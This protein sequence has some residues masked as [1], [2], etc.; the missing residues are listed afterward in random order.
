[1]VLRNIKLVRMSMIATD[2]AAIEGSTP[3]GSGPLFF[4]PVVIR[5]TAAGI[6]ITNKQYTGTVRM[7]ISIALA[8]L[9]VWR[10]RTPRVDRQEL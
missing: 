10:I 1:M 5:F 3:R 9:C 2:A 7:V 4:I 8:S 6:Q